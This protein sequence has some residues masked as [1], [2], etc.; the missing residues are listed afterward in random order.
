MEIQL[1]Q[2]T[3]LRIILEDMKSLKLTKHFRI[4]LEDKSLE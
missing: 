4:N 3:F 1:K 2:I